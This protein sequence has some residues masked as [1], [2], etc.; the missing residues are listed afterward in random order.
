MLISNSIGEMCGGTGRV[1]LRN[2]YLCVDE[3]FFQ[4]VDIKVG[5]NSGPIRSGFVGKTI[6]GGSFKLFGDVMNVASRMCSNSKRCCV[7]ASQATGL[8]FEK[9]NY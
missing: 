7:T 6:Y 5:V 3:S 8:F 1:C 4:G 2:M 9:K